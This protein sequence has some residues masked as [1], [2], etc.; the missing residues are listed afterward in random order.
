MSLSEARSAP[1]PHNPHRWR[2][3]DQDPNSLYTLLA[4]VALAGCQA[5]NLARPES[6]TVSDVKARLSTA[7]WSRAETIP[8][9]PSNYHFA[10][11]RLEFQQGRSYRL[12]LVNSSSSTHTFTSE[13]FFT[14]NSVQAGPGMPIAASGVEL[15]PG[16]QKELYFVATAPGSYEFE[17][18]KLPHRRLGR[19]VRSRFADAK[20]GPSSSQVRYR[21]SR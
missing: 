2:A 12:H 16:E 6:P 20:S 5:P 7:D 11:E 19:Q 17:C 21:Q 1:R 4:G 18:S 14:G 15:A 13:S 9:T 3:R 10:P 8:L